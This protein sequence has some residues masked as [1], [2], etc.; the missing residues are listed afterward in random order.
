MSHHRTRSS[1]SRTR[2]FM[3]K[4]RSQT[5]RLFFLTGPIFP[6][7]RA[8]CNIL[9]HAAMP[10]C[11]DPHV[12]RPTASLDRDVWDHFRRCVRWTGSLRERSG[13]SGEKQLGRPRRPLALASPC[14]SALGPS[15]FAPGPI[16]FLPS[17]PIPSSPVA[18]GLL[19][20]VWITKRDQGTEAIKGSR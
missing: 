17:F 7:I 6:T 18:V 14:S 11:S 16:F 9:S 20:K 1:T 3:G 5:R 12:P 10:C 8:S 4:N 2:R 13:T 19:S 15:E